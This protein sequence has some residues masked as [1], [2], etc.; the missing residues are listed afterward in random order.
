MI[1]TP[2]SRLFWFCPP[3]P[4]DLKV[5][6]S[7]SLMVTEKTN[8]RGIVRGYVR[9]PVRVLFDLSDLP[10][11]DL[12]VAGLRH[13]QQLISIQDPVFQL[14]VH[15]PELAGIALLERII[16][17]VRMGGPPLPTQTIGHGR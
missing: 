4:P 15:L 1:R 10:L 8:S 3:L 12:G 5:C 6:T 9:R 11:D 2:V 16:Q 13:I 14:G 17:A 7:Q